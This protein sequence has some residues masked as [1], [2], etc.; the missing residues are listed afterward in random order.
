MLP[1]GYAVDWLA[2]GT[3]D[4]SVGLSLFTLQVT[5]KIEENTDI[6][7]DYIVETVMAGS[8]EVDVDVIENFS[9]G[10][11]SRNGGGDLIITDGNLPIINVRRIDVPEIAKVEHTD[12]RDKRPAQIVFGAGVAFF[13]G[14]GFLPIALFLLLLPVKYLQGLEGGTIEGGRPALILA[15]SVVAFISLVDI[16]LAVA[17]FFGRNW[18]RIWLML[19]CVLTATTAFIGSATGSEAVTLATSLPTVGVSILVLLALS[20]HRAREYAERGRR[21]PK[22]I[23]RSTM[24]S[25]V[26]GIDDAAGKGSGFQQRQLR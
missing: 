16:G 25:G 10:Y 17:V 22:R 26:P 8:P 24:A 15:G 2:G 12:S 19:S 1:G 14:L 4:K 13:R 20:S 6:E 21:I 3:Y 11:H 9:T 23:A 18:A 7:R 5:H